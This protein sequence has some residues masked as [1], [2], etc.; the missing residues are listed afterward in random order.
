MKK[1]V[2]SIMLCLA[3]TASAVGCGSGTEYFDEFPSVYGTV[4]RL[5][6]AV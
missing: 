4:G 5:L 6:Q 1:K 2:L 3:L